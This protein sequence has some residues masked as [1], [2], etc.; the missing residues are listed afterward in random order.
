MEV[1]R[2]FWGLAASGV[3]LAT[4]ALVFA[5]PVLLLGA[6]GIGTLLFL[7]QY[8][9]VQRLQSLDATLT[10]D[11]SLPAQYVKKD[12]ETAVTIRAQLA[13]PS[14]FDLSIEAD[15]PLVGDG[16]PSGDRTL[17][18]EP[19]DQSETTTFTVAWPVVGRA[20]FEE[21]TVTVSDPYGLFRETLPRGPTPTVT[22]EPRVPRNVHVGE[23]GDRGYASFGGHRSD[24]LGSGTDP[25]EIREYVPGD[26]VRNID[27]KATARLDTPHV[28]EYEVETDQQT[29][30]LFDHRARLTTGREGETP[31]EY[32]RE[33]ALTVAESAEGVNDPLGLATVDDGGITAWER[34]STKP[35]TYETVRTT[36]LDLEGGG[37]DSSRARAGQAGASAGQGPGRARRKATLLAGEDSAYSQRVR[38]FFTESEGYVQQLTGDQLFEATRIQLNRVSEAAWVLIFTDD[39]ERAQLR[40]TVKLA[41]Q[42][43]AGVVVFVTPRVLFEREGL[44]DLDEAYEAFVA[45]EEF[46]RELA[47]LDGVSALEVAPGERID[48]VLAAGRKRRGD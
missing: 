2:R 15:L 13:E 14:V 23:G 5:R 22:V 3:A 16:P 24:Q 37:S 9:F 45:F 11:Q 6:A 26:S 30:I 43:A 42:Q 44:A 36:L 8:R 31:L 17:T 39:A 34:P 29:L 46:R 21:P 41:R 32:L 48:A 10:V 38:P 25:A 7:A 28:R 1:T 27:W 20:T 35:E 12:D 19:G 18:L 4:L 33:V 47:R 40:E